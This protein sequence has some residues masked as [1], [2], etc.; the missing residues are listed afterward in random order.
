MHNKAINA[1]V[2]KLHRSSLAMQLFA[3]GYDKR[4]PVLRTAVII[5]FASMR[6]LFWPNYAIHPNSNVSFAVNHED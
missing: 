3:S 6:F 5:C 4:S 2:K 1:D